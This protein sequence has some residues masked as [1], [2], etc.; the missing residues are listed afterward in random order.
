[1]KSLNIITKCLFLSLIVLGCNENPID[2]EQYIKQ[3]YLVGAVDQFYTSDISYSDQEQETF[4]SVATGGS[5]NIDKDAKVTLAEADSSVIEAY[6][7]KFTQRGAIR[8]QKLPSTHYSISSMN[9]TIKAGDVYSRIPVRIKTTGLHCDSLYVIPFKIASSDLTI[10]KKDS[11]LFLS[12][13]LINDYSGSYQLSGTVVQWLNGAASGA[14]SSLSIV[15]TLKAV[16]QYTVRLYNKT[17]VENSDNISSGCLTLNV[18][19][20]DNSVSIAGWY[21]LNITKGG[22]TYDPA[23]KTFNIWYHFMDGTTEYRVEAT[24]DK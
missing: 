6:N 2:T 20:T 11:V 8:Y 3:V 19:P 13:K 4:I 12:V 15:R 23:N 9:V 21:A 14:P 10:N 5:L 22:G 24:L 1:M 17:I 16:D 7:N 18:N